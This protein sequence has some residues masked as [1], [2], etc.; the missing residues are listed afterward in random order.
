MNKKWFYRYVGDERKR[1]ENVGLLQEKMGDL[2]T[3][4][5]EK[6]KVLSSFASVSTINFSIHNSHRRERQRLGE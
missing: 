5:L 1:R 4:D 6:A 2:V 3:Q